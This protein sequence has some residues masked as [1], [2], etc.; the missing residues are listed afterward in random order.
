VDIIRTVSV[1]P[2]SPGR[3]LAIVV[4]VRTFVSFALDLELDG[5][6]PWQGRRASRQRSS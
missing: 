5:K 4:A 6:W 3:L 1:A 2:T